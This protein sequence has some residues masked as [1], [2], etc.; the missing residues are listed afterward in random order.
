MKPE[1]QYV[2]EMPRQVRSLETVWIPL[3]DG[4]RLAARVWLP[5]D[6]EDRR[7]YENYIKGDEYR[8]MKSFYEDFGLKIDLEA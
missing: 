5:V 1:L 2:S 4:T 8:S 6:A 3:P 7:K